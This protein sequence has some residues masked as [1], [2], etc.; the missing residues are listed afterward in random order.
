MPQDRPVS[1]A[2]DIESLVRRRPNLTE[3][4]IAEALFANGYQQRVNPTCRQLVAERRITR[5]GAGGIDD[6]FRYASLSSL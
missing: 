1:L 2:D 6:P 5:F 4:Q 3:R